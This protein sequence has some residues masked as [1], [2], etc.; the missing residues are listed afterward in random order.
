MLEIYRSNSISQRNLTTVRWDQ[1]RYFV[2]EFSVRGGIPDA[3]IAWSW[4]TLGMGA[5]TPSDVMLDQNGNLHVQVEPAPSEQDA[6]YDIQVR[7][8]DSAT[9]YADWTHRIIVQKEGFLTTP[10][11]FPEVI[12]GGPVSDS[13]LEYTLPLPGF[14]K[15]LTS[16]DFSASPDSELPLQIKN[17]TTVAVTLPASELV[18]RTYSL[19]VS[20]SGQVV[21]YDADDNEIYQ[22]MDDVIEFDLIIPAVEFIE[23]QNAYIPDP[24]RLKARSWSLVTSAIDMNLPSGLVAQSETER[25][26]AGSSLLQGHAYWIFNTS[27]Q[28]QPWLVLQ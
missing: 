15:T 13:G 19:A 3:T 24:R 1:S 23:R 16:Y 25:L 9:T 20:A 5:P 12:V 21:T 2:L 17:G 22:T 28:D 4:S 8:R 11:Y 27:T 18:Q 14:G 10:S 6:V 26:D 7:A